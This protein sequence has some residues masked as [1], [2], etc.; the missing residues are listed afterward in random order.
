MLSITSCKKDRTMPRIPDRLSYSEALNIIGND[1]TQRYL[2]YYNDLR[3]KF[4]VDVFPTSRPNISGRV[5]GATAIPRV[6]VYPKH[7]WG[8]RE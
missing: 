1:N 6:V 5:L 8:Q 7:R 3:G 2:V 4:H